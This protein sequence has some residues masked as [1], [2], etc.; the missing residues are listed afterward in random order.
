VEDIRRW[1]AEVISAIEIVPVSLYLFRR[2]A[3]VP[4]VFSAFCVDVPVNVLDFGRVAI[5]IIAAADGRIA[6]HPYRIEFLVQGLILR[7]MVVKPSRAVWDLRRKVWPHPVLFQPN[8][9]LF[10][11]V[12]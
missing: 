12:H 10:R 8:R 9:P 4:S 7:R 5:R 1:S 11:E 6:T 2:N 3:N